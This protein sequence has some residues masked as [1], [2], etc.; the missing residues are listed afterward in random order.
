[1]TQPAQLSAPR[2][3]PARLAKKAAKRIIP[4]GLAAYFIPVTLAT[5]VGI[6]LLDV[7]RNQRRTISTID[8][9]FA[10]NG[11][12]TWL[13]APFNLLMDLLALPYRNK[14]IYKLTDLPPDYRDEINAL[15]AAAH[16]SDLVAK[17]DAKL[18][19]KKRG[20]IFFK[21]YG[22][23]VQTSVEVPEFHRAYKYVRTIGV[24][25]F[26]T[27]Q[28]TGK[29][30]GPL[31]VTLRVLYNINPIQSPDAYIKVGHRIHRWRDDRLFIFDDTLQH[32]SCNQSDEVRYCLFVDILRPS[33]MP[34]VMDAIL[35]GVRTLI[36]R[37][38]AA[39]YKHWSFIK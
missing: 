4:V 11:I 28:S 18:G 33:K 32:Q 24:S 25:I 38:N 2:V 37:F 15:I 12:F 35:S 21:W 13:L 27:R 20:M 10:G 26:N 30:F 39:F 1:M 23:N 22:K 8:R 5:Y 16:E 6:G 34:R 17:L 29:H 14:G 9:Y 19:D 36:S 7:L 3:N 31:R